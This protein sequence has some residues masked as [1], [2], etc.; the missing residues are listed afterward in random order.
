MKYIIV[1]WEANNC[2][3]I[4][5]I[6][7]VENENIGFISADDFKDAKVFDSLK[8]AE[9]T[10]IRLQEFYNETTWYIVIIP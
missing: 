6:F 4:A 2:W 9:K 5:E 7:K 8:D 10:Q 1:G 3:K